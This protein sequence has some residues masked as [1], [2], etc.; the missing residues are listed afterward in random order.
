MIGRNKVQAVQDAATLQ[1]ANGKSVARQT[2]GS[3]RFTPLVGF[4]VE[5]TKDKSFDRAMFDAQTA[6]MESSTSAAAA[7]RSSATGS[8]ASRCAST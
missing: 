8:S 7:P 5:V 4:H 2:L 6:Q 3:G 1:Y